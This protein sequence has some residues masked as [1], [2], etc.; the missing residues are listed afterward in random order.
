M[1]F[2]FSRVRVLAL[3]VALALVL[4][5]GV[6]GSPPR[7]ETRPERWLATTRTV[8]SWGESVTFRATIATIAIIPPP[9]AT[10]ELERSYDGQ[11]W[12]GISPDLTSDG[13]GTHTAVHRPRLTALYRAVLRDANGAATAT[14][15]RVGVMVRQLAIQRPVHSTAKVIDRGTSVTFTTTIRPIGPDLP[16]PR[17]AFLVYRRVN[18]TWRS[19]TFRQVTADPATGVARLTWRFTTPGEWYIR[20]TGM[21]NWREFIDDPGTNFASVLTPIARY[22]VV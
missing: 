4:P 6:S 1:P 2:V 15:E 3:L 18:G 9:T 13:Q 10:I 5:A 17:V 12:G 22:R 21:G 16:A 11:T 7:T 14:S 8:V 19:V 20:S